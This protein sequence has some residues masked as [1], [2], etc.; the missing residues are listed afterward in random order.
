MLDCLSSRGIHVVALSIFRR[1]NDDIDKSDV[2][3][4]PVMYVMTLNGYSSGTGSHLVYIH[5]DVNIAAKQCISCTNA[6]CYNSTT[7]SYQKLHDEYSAR[8]S[9]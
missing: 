8:E 7:S 5:N 6:L 1:T 3:G 4:A 9:Q 2:A